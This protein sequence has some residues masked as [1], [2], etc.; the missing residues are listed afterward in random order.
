MLSLRNVSRIY[1]AAEVKTAA[2]K[3]I[4]LTISAGEFIAI[5]GPSDCGKS[6]LL[7]ILGMLDVPSTG[8]YQFFGE[9]VHGRSEDDLALLRRQGVAYIFQNFNLLPGLT[10]AA[11]REDLAQLAPFVRDRVSELKS[12]DQMKLLTVR[13]DHL[14]RWYRAGLLCIGDAAHAMSPLG[15]VGINLAVQDAVAAANILT[16]PLREGRL[17]LH[18]L[19]AVQRRRELPARL[20]QRMQIFFQNRVIRRAL[21]VDQ[22]PPLALPLRL[23]RAWPLL[24][25]LPARLIG[26]GFR[27]EHIRVS[28]RLSRS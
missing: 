17:A 25:R 20:I 21:G 16:V 7:N 22:N 10:V 1:R 28:T 12:W 14:R 19:A 23:L 8:E 9:R 26:I 3:D 6:T 5:T 11:F 15:G 4:S 27:P 24:R 18:D 2:L 13:V